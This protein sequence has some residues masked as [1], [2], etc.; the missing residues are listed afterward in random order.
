MANYK[1]ANHPTWLGP[2]KGPA[3]R[4]SNPSVQ[5]AS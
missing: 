3:A 5:K 1:L 2:Q 4:V